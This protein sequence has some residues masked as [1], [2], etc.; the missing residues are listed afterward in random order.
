MFVV[1]NNKTGEPLY[2]CNTWN[3]VINCFYNLTKN[4]PLF[5]DFTKEELIEHITEKL[6]DNKLLNFTVYDVQANC[7]TYE[8]TDDIHIWYADD[9]EEALFSAAEYIQN[10]PEEYWPE[11]EKQYLLKELQKSYE[12][13]KRRF[14]VDGVIWCSVWE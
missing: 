5:N 9:E 13:D 12:E 10:Q 6:K 2:A 14:G 11:D 4:N 8:I 1:V 7:D 3:R